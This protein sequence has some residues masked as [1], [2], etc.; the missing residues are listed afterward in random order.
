M[1]YGNAGDNIAMLPAPD[2][3]GLLLLPNT[4]K[5]IQ[6]HLVALA[7]SALDILIR[8]L[9]AMLS[10]ESGSPTG[11]PMHLDDA[12]NC[13]RNRHPQLAALAIFPPIVT[14]R[15]SRSDIAPLRWFDRLQMIRQ[16]AKIVRQLQVMAQDREESGKQG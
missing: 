16:L 3:D 9:H 8:E 2:P 12:L 1:V 4:P 7:R 13:V 10:R 6:L 11:G 14:L 5:L 15:V